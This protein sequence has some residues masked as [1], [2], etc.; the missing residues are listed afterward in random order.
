[1]SVH[2]FVSPRQVDLTGLSHYLDDLNQGRR[3]R[4][5]RSMSA[6]EQ[7]LLFDAAKGHRPLTLA[8]FVPE[9]ARPLQ[10]VIHFGCNSLPTF[11]TFEKRFCRPDSTAAPELWGYNE[12]PMRCVTGP[13]YFVT[14]QADDNEVVIDYFDIPPRKPAEWPELAPNSSR[15]GRFIYYKTRDYMRG[16]SRHLT[17]GRASREGKAMDNWFVLCREDASL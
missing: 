15:L 17:V 10:P 6:A 13:G 3:V 14:R 5:V 8:D 2:D 7:A 12:Q 9:A 11:R 4:A 16:V 1:M